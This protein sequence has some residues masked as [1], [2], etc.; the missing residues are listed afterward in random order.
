MMQNNENINNNNMQMNTNYQPPPQVHQNSMN[1]QQKP[2]YPMDN[3]MQNNQ[4]MQQNM[5]MPPQ[6]QMQSQPN[7]MQNQINKRQGSHG[8]NQMKNHKRALQPS[9]MNNNN[10]NNNNFTLGN[11]NQSM[12]YSSH[13]PNKVNKCY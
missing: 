9:N 5:K 13:P 8:M 3:N 11:K 12:Q 2:I 6:N 4:N 7:D 1:M 10:N